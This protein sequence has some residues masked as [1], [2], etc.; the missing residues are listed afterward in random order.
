[1]LIEMNQVEYVQLKGEQISDDFYNLT[2]GIGG[3]LM[4]AWMI[5]ERANMGAVVVKYQGQSIGWCAFLREEDGIYSLGTYIA[6]EYR[7]LG[8]GRM[9]LTLLVECIKEENTLAY[10]KY[11]GSSIYEFQKTYERT[12][13]G[14]GLKTASIF[15]HNSRIKQAA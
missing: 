1:M 12:I 13:T 2:N 6:K 14:V 9:A 15:E 8:F 7:G 3:G 11:G 5:N 4:A 10:C